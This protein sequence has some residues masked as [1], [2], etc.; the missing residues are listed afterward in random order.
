MIIETE[1][2]YLRKIIQSDYKD[3]AEILQD[4]ETMT[5]YEH[6]FRDEEVQT[7]LNRQC[8]RYQQ[9]GF[10]LWA[11]IDKSNG[12]FLGQCGLT[13]QDVEGKEELEIGYLFK[14]T[15]WHNGY[16]TEAAQGTLHYALEKLNVKRVVCTIRDTN[17]PSQ[18]VAKRL[19]MSVEKIFVKHYY[20]IDMPHLLYVIES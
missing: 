8:E 7:W 14:R 11:V 3:L 1:R 6:A 20:G 16:A 15:H 5:A 13:R 17:H 12:R 10:G 18:R 4:A 9:D 2:L 19:G